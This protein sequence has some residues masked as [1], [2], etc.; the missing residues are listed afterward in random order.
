MASVIVAIAW[1]CAMLTA[2]FGEL[3]MAISAYLKKLRERVGHDLLLLPGV[4]ALVFNEAGE[5]LLH[6]R[7]DTGNWA[8][9]GGIPDPD[10]ELADAIAREVLEETGVKVIPERI[11]GIY[12]R[13]NMAYP[14]GDRV[15]YTVIAFLCRPISGTPRVNDDES[16]EV[17]YFPL[18]RLPELAPGQRVRIDHA[19]RPPGPVFFVPAKT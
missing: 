2:D 1:V 12:T 6:K 11:T 15:Q 19:L 10:E 13:F 7:A 8:L 17:G 9:M 14:N 18:D 5:I 4:C 3:A 16:L